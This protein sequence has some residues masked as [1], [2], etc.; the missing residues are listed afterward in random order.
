MKRIISNIPAVLVSLIICSSNSSNQL[1]AQNV[2][3]NRVN[4]HNEN[5]FTVLVPKG[6][7]IAGGIFRV[8]PSRQGGAA[9]SIA[10]KVDFA[11]KKDAAGTVMI[12]WLPDVLFYDARYSPAGQMGM[13]PQG[14]NYNG[15]TVH[16]LI[17][18]RQFIPDIAIPYAHPNASNI[19]VT[20]SKNL[21]DIAKNYQR[22]MHALVPMIDFGY[23]AALV[24]LTYTENGV[25]YIEKMICIIENWGRAGAGMWG[26]KETFYVRTPLNEF[27]KYESIMSVIQ[28]S[29]IINK[30]WLAGEL[31]GQQK[32]G[33]IMINTQREMQRIE[34]QMTE[35]RRKTNAE[36]HNDMFLT[37]TDQEEYVNPF[38]NEV[39]TGSNQWKYRWENEA[40]DIIYT[41]NEA[42]DPRVDINLNRTDYKRTPIRERFPK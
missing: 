14:S 6:W 19:R 13:F 18:A 10:A 17:S 3:F 28:N 34:N 30:Q 16:N 35:H 41:D 27:S 8:D 9:Q 38:T 20:E 1:N 25:K 4:E 23:D 37:L 39:E 24:T 22:R 29:I 12:R 36:I 21:E 40:G 5:A 11:V 33:E 7:Q 31:K 32:R 15:M 42:Y 2:I 26:N